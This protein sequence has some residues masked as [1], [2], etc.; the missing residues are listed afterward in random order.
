MESENVLQSPCLDL[1]QG[2]KTIQVVS[3]FLCALHAHYWYKFLTTNGGSSSARAGWI[4][5]IAAA[6]Y[7]SC[8]AMHRRKNPVP[9]LAPPHPP[10]ESWDAGDA[11]PGCKEV[12]WTHGHADHQNFLPTE[13]AISIILKDLRFFFSCLGGTQ[14]ISMTRG[15]QPSFLSA[16]LFVC[17]SAPHKNVRTQWLQT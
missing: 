9:F 10:E 12:A 5:A 6:H 15:Q 13:C 17:P 14:V 16:G 7:G 8:I 2:T 1:N 4:S 3:D 11:Q